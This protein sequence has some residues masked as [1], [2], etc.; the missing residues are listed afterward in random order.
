MLV[1]LT[2][3]FNP[4]IQHEPSLKT[5]DNHSAATLET[6]VHGFSFAKLNGGTM[7]KANQFAA[8]NRDGH[9]EHFSDLLITGQEVTSDCSLMDNS[10]FHTNVTPYF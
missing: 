4:I 2:K 8:N 9:K 1:S 10:E 7:I 3:C 6:G 5:A